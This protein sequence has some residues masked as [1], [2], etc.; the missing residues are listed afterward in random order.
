MYLPGCPPRPEMLMDAIVKLH[1]KILA[2]PVSGKLEHTAAGSS[3]YPKPIEVATA[4]SRLPAG[5]VDTRT[6]SVN[7]RK[8]FRLPAGAPAPTD[9]G[10][11]TG[12]LDERSPAA[13]VPASVFG[14]DKSGPVR[15]VGD[16]P[17]ERGETP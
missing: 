17:N 1:E 8:R 12:A 5:A 11:V 6:L 9:S 2:G 7:D 4:Q 14:R 3:P 15:D 16:V 10:A 13:V